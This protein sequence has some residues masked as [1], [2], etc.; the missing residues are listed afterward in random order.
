MYS[1][2]VEKRLSNFKKIRKIGEGTYGEVY[3]AIDLSNNNRVA[4]KKIR[5]ENKDEGIPITALREMCIL[6]H[7]KHE[8]IV[9]L[10]E[11]IQDIEKIIL[12]F[13]YVDQDLKMYIDTNKGIKNI[14]EVKVSIILIL[15]I[16]VCV[17]NNK[18]PLFLSHQSYYP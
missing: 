12:I 7:L 6:K 15:L 11:I 3:E 8:N 9:D 13:E 16:V 2:D 18:R 4:L 10:Y 17:S 5:I 1:I 14:K